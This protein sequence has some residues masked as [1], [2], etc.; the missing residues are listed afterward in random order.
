[1][2]TLLREDVS[3]EPEQQVGFLRIVERQSERLHQLIEDLLVASRVQ[4]SEVNATYAT[5]SVP[6][7][8]EQVREE[9]REESETH[10]LTIAI[11]KDMPFVMSD[12]VKL[13]QIVANLLDN[14]FK[15]S[16]AGTEVKL[17]VERV[18]D[19]VK[20][21]VTD[22]G[23]GVPEEAREKIFDRFYQADQSATRAA[24][25][26]GLGLY[27]CRNLAVAIGGRVWL[28]GTDDLGSV[29]AVSVPLRPDEAARNAPQ[30]LRAL[31]A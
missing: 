6:S 8:I 12:P 4:S 11:D 29:F 3:F 26:T 2:K 25:G 24:G 17:H 30:N 28:E 7:L 23:A 31:G 20:I 10:R 21:S 13:H 22:Q 1:V 16:P 5:F 15:Y 9:F 14:A 19:A 18:G 27:I